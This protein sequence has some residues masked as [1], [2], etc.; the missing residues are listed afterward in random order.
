MMNPMEPERNTENRQRNRQAGNHAGN[1]EYVGSERNHVGNAE[2]VGSEPEVSGSERYMTRVA[3]T[4]PTI[5][6]QYMRKF[7][8]K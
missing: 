2:Y 5:N 1:A 7:K 8:Q 4:Q 6:F 3:D